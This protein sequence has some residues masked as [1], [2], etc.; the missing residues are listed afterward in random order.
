M[1]EQNFKI[2]QFD[3]PPRRMIDFNLDAKVKQGID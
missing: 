3:M 1:P 2:E